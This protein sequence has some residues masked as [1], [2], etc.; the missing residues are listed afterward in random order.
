MLEQTREKQGLT[1][2]QI[3]SMI[4]RVLGTHG[5]LSKCSNTSTWISSSWQA[6]LRKKNPL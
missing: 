5:A 2:V 1:I 6:Y 3:F 4:A